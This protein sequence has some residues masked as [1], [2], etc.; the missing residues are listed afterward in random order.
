MAPAGGRADKGLARGKKGS[1][2][3]GDLGAGINRPGRAVDVDTFMG[4]F[5]LMWADG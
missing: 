2:Y 4:S 3:T 1:V 5:Q